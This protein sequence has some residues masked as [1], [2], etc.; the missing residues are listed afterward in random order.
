[1]YELLLFIHIACAIIWV[2]GA[3]TVQLFALRAERS[4]DPADLPR[5]GSTAEFIGMRIFLPASLLLFVAGLIMVIQRWS[6]GDLWVSVS[7]ALW[8]LSVLVGALYLGPRT[9]KIAALFAAEGPTSVAGRA[10]LAR[11]FLVSRLEL[12]S[13]AIIVALMTF[14]PGVGG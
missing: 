5:I 14:K 7:M 10:G 9:G 4:T 2:G 3:V 13:F 12:I 6:F 1:V 8:L 11:L